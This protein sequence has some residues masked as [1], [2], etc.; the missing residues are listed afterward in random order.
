[1]G[2]KT[3]YAPDKHLFDKFLQSELITRPTQYKKSVY[4]VSYSCYSINKMPCYCLFFFFFGWRFFSFHSFNN[5]RSLN[6]NTYTGNIYHNLRLNRFLFERLKIFP[7]S[8]LFS[9]LPPSS[10]LTF[11]LLWKSWEIMTE[12]RGKNSVCNK[13]E[14]FINSDF[15]CNNH[16]PLDNLVFPHSLSFI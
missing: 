1:M 13:N 7:Y 15:L 10:Q 4:K 14:S 16:T 5:I 12:N 2:E 6:Q 8:L 11:C 3:I 9:L